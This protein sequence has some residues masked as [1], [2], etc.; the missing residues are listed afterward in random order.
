MKYVIL[1]TI[2]AICGLAT[3]CTI[4]TERTVVQRPAPATAYVYESPSTVYVGPY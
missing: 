1:A 4:S 3:A 2:A